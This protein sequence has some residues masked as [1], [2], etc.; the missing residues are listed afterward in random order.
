MENEVKSKAEK[1]ATVLRERKIRGYLT[2]GAP[3]VLVRWLY[4]I[5]A[6]CVVQDINE[7]EAATIEEN[8]D[9]NSQS[10]GQDS[11]DTSPFFSV[12]IGTRRTRISTAVQ[13][14]CSQ[15]TPRDLESIYASLLTPTDSSG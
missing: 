6:I 1:A 4:H 14:R 12:S 7:E 8:V 11:L 2:A 5:G 9:E 13:R 15:K 3:P 10:V